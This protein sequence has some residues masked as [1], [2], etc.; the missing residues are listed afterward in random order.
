MRYM[1]IIYQGAKAESPEKVLL[2][3]KPLLITVLS[4]GLMV[5]IIL[6]GVTP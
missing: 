2:A 3:D 4:W 1:T 6:Y 5:I